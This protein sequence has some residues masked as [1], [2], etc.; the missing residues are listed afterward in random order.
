[1]KFLNL[2]ASALAL[3]VF[4]PVAI[5]APASASVVNI[6]FD[7]V[8]TGSTAT[9]AAPSG[10]EFFQA[11]FVNDLDVWGDEIANTAKWQIDA[12]TDATT[13]VTVENPA[14]NGYGAAPSG[15]NALDARWQPVLMH[16]GAAQNL[17][18]FSVT[19][20]NSSFG[21]LF[22][23]ALYFLD[24]NKAIIGQVSFDQTVLGLIVNLNTPLAGVQDVVL[25]SGAFYDN[26][27]YETASST[28]VPIPATFPL[29]ITGLGL[30]SILR[31][32]KKV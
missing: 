24:A 26:F 16:F 29:L 18:S 23:S 11:H 10:V 15:T 3:A 12:D 20:D 7:N 1:M 5:T 28:S 25:S 21:D 4:A 14:L 17:N 19:L 31:L 32:R 22:N 13:P 6:N 27:V 8:T 2:K 9:S 30:L